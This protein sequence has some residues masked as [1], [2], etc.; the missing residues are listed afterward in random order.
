MSV[1]VT[2]KELG[3]TRLLDNLLSIGREVVDICV[4][5]M[6]YYLISDAA[7]GVVLVKD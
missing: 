4:F 3:L 1:H 7:I 2:F 6:K 5:N